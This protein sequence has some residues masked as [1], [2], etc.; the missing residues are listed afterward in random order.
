MKQCFCIDKK[1]SVLTVTFFFMSEYR[2]CQP[3][4]TFAVANTVLW[5]LAGQTTSGT[6][7]LKAMK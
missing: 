7:H 2:G 6:C 5:H 3:T 4:D 1:G